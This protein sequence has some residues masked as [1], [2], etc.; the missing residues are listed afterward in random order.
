MFIEIAVERE[1][2]PVEIFVDTSVESDSKL[3]D[4]LDDIAELSES[5]L[6]DMS[7]DITVDKELKESLFFQTLSALTQTNVS[8]SCTDDITTSV[9]PDS[10]ILGLIPLIAVDRDSTAVDS[11]GIRFVVPDSVVPVKYIKSPSK[12]LFVMFS[13][14]PLIAMIAVD[15]DSSAL[16]L[17]DASLDIAVLRSPSAT[18]LF[19]ASVEIAPNNK[20]SLLVLV[21]ISAEIVNILP[22][23]SIPIPDAVYEPGADILYHSCV[24]TPGVIVSPVVSDLPNTQPLE[25]F[26]VPVSTK[27]KSPS[28]IS[29]SG[30]PSASG[31]RDQEPPEL[32]RYIPFSAL[33]V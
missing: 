15:K 20:S 24:L 11:D 23:N 19:E 13:V 10:A 12:T 16:V 29:L 3:D 4:M 17:M 31:L 2:L 8:L 18:D 7:V 26:V 14:S 22:T 28:S 27:T 21:E 1:S 6:F 33:L 5:L 9:N 32:T 30:F 25:P